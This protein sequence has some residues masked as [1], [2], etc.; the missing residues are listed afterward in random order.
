VKLHLVEP[1]DYYQKQG[2][3]EIVSMLLIKH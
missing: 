2:M 3:S 1:W